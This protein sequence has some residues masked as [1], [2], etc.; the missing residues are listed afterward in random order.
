MDTEPS[1]TPTTSQRSEEAFLV[2]ARTQPMAY[3]VPDSNLIALGDSVCG[4]LNRGVTDTE[5]M[6]TLEQTYDYETSGHILAA[7]RAFLCPDS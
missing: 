1:P 4:A 6:A 5:V 7:S 2:V 3:G